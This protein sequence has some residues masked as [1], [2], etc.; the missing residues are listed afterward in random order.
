MRAEMN[1]F[2]TWIAYEE[3]KQLSLRVESMLIQSGFH[4]VNKCE[5]FFPVQGY[6]GLWLLAESHFAVHSFPED[7]KIYLELTSCVVG[8]FEKMK[9]EIRKEFKLI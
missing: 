6:T 5:H 9:N 3:E 4:V 2:S 7:G 8:P 1:H